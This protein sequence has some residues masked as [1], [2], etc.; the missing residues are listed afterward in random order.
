MLDEYYRESDPAKRRVVL[1][2]LTPE[3]CGEEMVGQIKKL[4]ELRYSQD[5]KGSYADRFLGA[6]MELIM[7]ANS[8]DG[9]FSRRTRQKSFQKAMQKLCLEEGAGF[10][11]DVLYREM[12]HL[13][14]TY[15]MTCQQDG[16]Y[17]SILFGLGRISDERLKRKITA[18]LE[19]IRQ[20]V[21]HYSEPEGAE[22]VLTEAVA[23]VE[24]GLY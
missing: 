16:T 5:N 12:C 4:Y 17:Q 9:F 13:A 15:I 6:W 8:A 24:K 23:E 18:D 19:Q 14:A 7:L 20:C 1:E 11:R 22:S 10:S 2:T 3:E 21:L